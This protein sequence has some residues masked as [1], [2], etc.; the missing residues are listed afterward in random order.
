MSLFP[1]RPRGPDP[2]EGWS[3]VAGQKPDRRAIFDS[4]AFLCAEDWRGFLRKGRA[5]QGHDP[6]FMPAPP[7]RDLP[8]LK[9]V[10][11]AGEA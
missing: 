11:K 8:C 7:L 2:F 4:P 9:F 1:P 3:G 10:P 6:F 5:Y